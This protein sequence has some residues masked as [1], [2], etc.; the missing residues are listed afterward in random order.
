MYLS[1]LFIAVLVQ[2]VI[3]CLISANNGGLAIVATFIY[4]TDKNEIKQI[5]WSRATRR[6]Q[7]NIFLCI[8]ITVEQT[9]TEI[10]FS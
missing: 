6:K 5:L 3:L 9:E 8:L 10:A 4:I 1:D 7:M 2:N